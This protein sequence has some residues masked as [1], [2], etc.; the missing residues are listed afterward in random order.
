MIEQ[1][2]RGGDEDL[3]S[4]L[5]LL[6]LRIHGHATVHDAGAERDMAAVGADRVGDLHRETRGSA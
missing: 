3:E 1:A 4:P 6:G 2:A 5:Q